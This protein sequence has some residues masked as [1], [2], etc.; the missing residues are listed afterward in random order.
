MSRTR[1]LHK[2][3]SQR[4]IQTAMVDLV[5]QYGI[6][7]GDKLVL[8]RKN[9]ESLLQAL[10]HMKKNL[11]RIHSAGGVAV[12]EVG[13]AQITTYALDSYSRSKAKGH[14]NEEH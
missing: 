13:D 11:M 12:V 3:M 4:G 2:R 14:Q 8:D 5:S 9:T 7:D 6:E 10:D 1:H